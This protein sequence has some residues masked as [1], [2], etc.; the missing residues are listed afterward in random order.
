ME[1]PNYIKKYDQLT[2]FSPLEELLTQLVKEK[3]AFFFY[4]SSNHDE[5]GKSWCDDCDSARPFIDRG[6]K[7]F[8]NENTVPFI[9]CSV[10]RDTWRN[11]SN[12]YRTHNY[13]KLKSVPTLIYFDKGVEF[14]RLVEANL[15][16]DEAIKD[17]FTHPSEAKLC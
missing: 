15:L 1:A 13:L 9:Y 3:K 5:T 16:N 11:Q 17:F 7:L 14:G 12:F 8:S 6:L 4:A 10:D 2:D